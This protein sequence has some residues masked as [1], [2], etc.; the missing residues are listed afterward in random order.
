[1]VYKSTGLTMNF[2]TIFMLTVV[3]AFA[4]AKSLVKR[5]ASKF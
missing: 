3:I 4:Q 2:T 5:N 1:M